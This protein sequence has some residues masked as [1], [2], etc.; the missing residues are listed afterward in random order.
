M[1]LK[2]VDAHF[3]FYNKKINFYP[4]LSNSDEKLA[5]LWGKNYPQQ[6]P[7]SYLPVESYSRIWC[8]GKLN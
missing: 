6:L 3:H 4:F 5:L 1:A 7:E 8:M 2:I